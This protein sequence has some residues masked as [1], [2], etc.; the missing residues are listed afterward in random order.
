MMHI[1]QAEVVTV[2]IRYV[3]AKQNIH[4][5]MVAINGFSFGHNCDLYCV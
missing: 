2:A 5:A 3:M 4:N 1:V